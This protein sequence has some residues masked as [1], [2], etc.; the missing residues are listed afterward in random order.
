M[1]LLTHE[2]VIVCREPLVNCSNNYNLRKV[3]RVLYFE[4]LIAPDI[5]ITRLITC[6]FDSAS[7][8]LFHP[9]DLHVLT[10]RLG[11]GDSDD[12]VGGT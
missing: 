9:G 12:C 6:Q 11:G 3:A 2:S 10:I 5:V 7:A 8:A 1:V 4:F